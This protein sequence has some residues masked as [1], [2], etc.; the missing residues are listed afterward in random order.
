KRAYPSANISDG[1]ALVPQGHGIFRTLGIRQN[2][3][4]GGFSITD[5]CNPGS[6]GFYLVWREYALGSRWK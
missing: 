2:L 4:P 1:L 5:R 6:Y 3:E